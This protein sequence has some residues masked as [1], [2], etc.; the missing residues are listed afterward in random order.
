M[1]ALQMALDFYGRYGIKVQGLIHHSDRGVQYASREYVATLKQNG[2]LISMTQTGDPLHNAL[3][4]RMNN[5]IKNGW[6][7]DY[8]DKTFEQALRGVRQA[9]YRYNWMRPHQA[10]AMKTP[11]QMMPGEHPN[12]LLL[13]SAVR[14]SQAKGK[15]T[16]N[17][18]GKI[19]DC[20]LK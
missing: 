15:G 13:G 2:I 6:L 7:Y 12:P 20:K 18:S 5:T 19:L 4:E 3:A 9:I 16:K 17:K 10:N 8:S 14:Q 1:E 11:M